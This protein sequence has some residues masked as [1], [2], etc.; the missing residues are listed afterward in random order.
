M[1]W[2]TVITALITAGAS[3]FGSWMVSTKQRRDDAVKEAQREQKQADRLDNIEKKL[4]I[5][6]GYAEK[7]TKITENIIKM[8]KDIEFLK[9]R[10]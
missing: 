5:H 10:S 2:T 1:E 8:E 9:Q 6:N 3:I 7:F 4:D